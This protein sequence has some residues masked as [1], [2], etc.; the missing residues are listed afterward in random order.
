MRIYLALGSNLGDRENYLHSGLRGLA[1]RDIHIT[2]CASLYS[3][4]PRE[5]LAQPWFLNTVVEANTILTPAGLL[6]ACLQ[7]EKEN[8][9]TRDGT[10]GPRTLD[11]DIIFYGNEIIRSSGLTIPHPSFALR[12]FVLAPLAEIASDCVD[13]TSGKTVAYLLEV[14]PDSAEVRRVGPLQ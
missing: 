8:H 14:C 4:E 2:R 10:K 5:I 7:I 6:D 3:T 9:R 11:I 1:D 12:R 13:P